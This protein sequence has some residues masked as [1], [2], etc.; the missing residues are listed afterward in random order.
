MKFKVGDKITKLT[1]RNPDDWEFTILKIVYENDGTFLLLKPYNKRQIKLT[2]V[3]EYHR[4]EAGCWNFC[5][6]ESIKSHLP[7]FL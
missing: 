1:L 4:Y 3:T 5:K 2:Y 6:K 7:D